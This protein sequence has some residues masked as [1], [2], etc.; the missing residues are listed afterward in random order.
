MDYGPLVY[1]VD[2]PVK[3]LSIEFS[4]ITQYK[5]ISYSNSKSFEL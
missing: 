1:K 5:V 4:C 3:E 2:N